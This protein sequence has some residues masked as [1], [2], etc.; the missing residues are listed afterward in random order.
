MK[1]YSELL[2]HWNGCKEMKVTNILIMNITSNEKCDFNRIYKA[3]R[4]LHIVKDLL[5]WKGEWEKKT[6]NEMC[7]LVSFPSGHNS[8]GGSRNQELHGNLP[9]G[10]QE[11]RCLSHH[12]LL[13]RCV[14][15]SPLGSEVARI[16]ID[17]LAS[18]TG[19]LSSGSIGYTAA[20]LTSVVDYRWIRSHR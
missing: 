10:W 14:S 6:N 8:Q 16:W 13:C 15:R 3:I 9:R 17:T 4:N 19:I 18:V 12:L 5:I 7:S 1:F 20:Y 2:S 11:C